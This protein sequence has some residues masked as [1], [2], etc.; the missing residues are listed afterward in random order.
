[1]REPT[2]EAE[3]YERLKKIAVAPEYKMR[4]REIFN[5]LVTDFS[6]LLHKETYLAL[7]EETENL[8]LDS[9]K[10]VLSSEEEIKSHT[11]E[12]AQNILSNWISLCR[13]KLEDSNTKSL[14]INSTGLPEGV[15]LQELFAGTEAFCLEADIV[16][17]KFIEF[18]KTLQTRPEPIE[19]AADVFMV[20]NPGGWNIQ[21]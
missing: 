7:R 17:Q 8:K 20:R 1:M 14:S 2:S 10:V 15:S 6:S 5:K 16:H 9:D 21:I 19:I 18:Q 12:L 3:E 11:K 4:A 13:H